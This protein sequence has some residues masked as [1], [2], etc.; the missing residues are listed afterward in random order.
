MILNKKLL[1]LC[2]IINK[3]HHVKELRGV[4][5]KD[6]EAIATDS[7]MLLRVKTESGSENT[8]VDKRYPN[9]PIQGIFNGTQLLNFLN[10]LVDF[11]PSRA[12]T[13]TEN[14]FTKLIT[15]DHNGTTI[16]E[17]ERIDGKYPEYEKLLVF[18]KPEVLKVRVNPKLLI[19][20]LQAIVESLIWNNNQVDL[21]FYGND[22]P[23]KIEPAKKDGENVTGILMPIRT[24]TD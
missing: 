22:Q 17:I 20:L 14:D 18:D 13:S 11:H 6:D 16:S 9:R 23:I 10:R 24:K 4:L 15:V 8:A 2:R 21:T 7:F 1:G 12:W 3:D 5:F 19:T